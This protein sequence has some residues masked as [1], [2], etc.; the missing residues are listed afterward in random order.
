M[1]L[2]W[3]GGRP[4]Y[5]L[6]ASASLIFLFATKE[7]AFIT[8]GTFVIAWI[9][10]RVWQ[11]IAGSEAVKARQGIY[12]SLFRFGVPIA[13]V[14]LVYSFFTDLSAFYEKYR[15]FFNDPKGPDQNFLF[16][17]ILV[18]IL[19]SALTWVIYS[20]G[21]GEDDGVD[22]G[23][24]PSFRGFR[25]A[26]GSRLDL[27]LI[28]V[29]ASFLF[30]YVGALFFSS[31]FTYP[32][33]V[34]GAFEAYAIWTRTGSKDHTQNGIWAYLR[35]LMEIESPI[36]ILSSVGTLIAVIRARHRFALFSG[37]WAFGLLAAYTIIPYKTPWLALSFILPMCIV[38]GYGIGRLA[39]SSDLVL[40]GMVAVLSVLS[41]AI[42]AFQAYDIN[43]VRYDDDR[44]PYVY[45]HTRR[46][47]VDLMD[48]IDRIAE[49]TDKKKEIAIDIV[50]PDYWPMPWYLNDYPNAV[51]HGGL[52]DSSKA[53]IVIA[54]KAQLADVDSR[55][56]ATH[57]V[58][59][60]NP[61]R[62]GVDLYL[63]VRKDV[64][65]VE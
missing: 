50:S 43:F 49:L 64:K 18:L 12:L 7:T 63:L 22:A 2:V 61:L 45:A 34:V 35:W 17:G 5:L 46:G 8:V 60:T 56:G 48:R 47:F 31:F 9:C 30:I 29:A 58:V 39:G 1:L 24:E 23:S 54:S 28:A 40:K 19:A 51:F 41:V 65:A 16:Y 57:N 27:V 4:I 20:A 13:A 26:I 36:L 53:E 62:P 38:A 33:G 6:L 55:Y 21:T 25:K 37:L 14:I 42:L 32:Q 11:K 52:T 59:G 3:N 15:N 10:V 44:M